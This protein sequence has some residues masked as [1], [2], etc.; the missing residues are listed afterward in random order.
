VVGEVVVSTMRQTVAVAVAEHTDKAQ[1]IVLEVGQ[2]VR[3]ILEEVIRLVNTAAEVAE[4]QPQRVLVAD[5]ILV[6]LVVLVGLLQSLAR[7]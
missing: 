3:V 2:L 4:E 6:V 1:A 7:Q 5:F